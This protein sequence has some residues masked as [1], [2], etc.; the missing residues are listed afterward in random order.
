VRALALYVG[1]RRPPE[2][3]GLGVATELNADFFEDC[4]GVALDDLD[5]FAAVRGGYRGRAA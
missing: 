5:R 3:Q 2:P 4:L 1:A